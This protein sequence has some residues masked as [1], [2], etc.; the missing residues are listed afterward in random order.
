M[1]IWML[2]LPREN[3][4]LRRRPNLSKSIAEQAWVHPSLYPLLQKN[5]SQKANVV[6][7]PIGEPLT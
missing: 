3:H 5:I 4:S 7:V 1:S 2:Q 6:L